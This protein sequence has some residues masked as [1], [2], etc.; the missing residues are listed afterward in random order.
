MNKI[1]QFVDDGVHNLMKGMGI[2][3]NLR[4]SKTNNRDYTTLELM[5]ENSWVARRIIEMPV[6]D[7]TYN[8]REINAQTQ[9][10]ID[11]F[12]EEEKRLE[13]KNI[14]EQAQ[15]SANLYGTAYVLMVADGEMNEPLPPNFTLE[16]LKVFDVRL[17]RPSGS[18]V[19]NPLDDNFQKPLHYNLQS[20]EIHHT[21][22]LVFIG[23]ELPEY[24]YRVNGWQH[25][26]VLLD[27]KTTIDNYMATQESIKSQIPEA[28]IAVLKINE[29]YENLLNEE[30]KAGVQQYT[31][32][33]AHT[34]SMHN[35]TVIDGA[36]SYENFENKAINNL[37]QLATTILN[38]IAVSA[39][40]PQNRFLGSTPA[41]LNAGDDTATEKRYAEHIKTLQINKWDKNLSVVDQGIKNNTGI[42]TTFEWI[43]IIPE[44]EIDKTT[45]IGL[46]ISNMKNL[47]EM[48]VIEENTIAKEVVQLGWYQNFTQEDIDQQ[49]REDEEFKAAEQDE[50]LQDQMYEEELERIRLLTLID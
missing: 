50:E 45:L 40:I 41:G 37:D 25:Q 26:S 9:E 19:Q 34:K 49:Q 20:I 30:T 31:R 36:D 1:K 8:W 47:L 44:T 5:Y 32:H 6:Q 2:D 18:I 15:I 46:N 27:K 3:N 23:N 28:G 11:L 4:Y 29:M 16:K 17:M 38:D 14:F 7:A 24:M 48:N 10:L 12:N 35:M 22:V 13:V 43:D 42:E 21:R 39:G 33:I